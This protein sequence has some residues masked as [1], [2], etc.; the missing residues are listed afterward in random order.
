MEA[1][2]TVNYW[3]QY[4]QA[5]GHATKLLHAFYFR[6]YIRRNK[7]DAADADA[8]LRANRDPELLP[9]PTKQPEQQALQS[10]HRSRQQLI[11][12]RTSRISF[13]RGVL[14]EFGVSLP[15]A[16]VRHVTET[17]IQ[18]K[19]SGR[20]TNTL[21]RQVGFH[22]FSKGPIYARFDRVV[23]RCMLCSCPMIL[24]VI[25]SRFCLLYFIHYHA[26][27]F[28]DIAKVGREQ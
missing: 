3:S 9:I 12:T 13:I 20:Q 5:H 7:T 2:A 17:F 27:H 10:L 11:E 23:H 8:L 6:S 14:A 28:F 19:G 4:A 21:V 18:G 16:A 25:V 1:C 15:R 26:F 24:A 22:T